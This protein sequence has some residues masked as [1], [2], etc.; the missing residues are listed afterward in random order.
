LL[1]RCPGLAGLVACD[2]DADRLATVA[3]TLA[4][5]GIEAELVHADAAYTDSLW[6]GRGFDRVLI[7]SPCS[8]LGVIRRHPDIKRLR[9]PADLAAA[10]SEQARLIERLWPLVA[11]GG[12]LV[13]VTCTVLAD[14]NERQ[15]ERFAAAPGAESCRVERTRQRLPGE[16]NMDGFYYA[17][18]LKQAEQQMLRV[19]PR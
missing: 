16:A 15:I 2:R 1:E 5:L 19:S 8:A 3:E 14:E 11:P 18:L 10:V 4:R 17:C 7:D 6:D 13:Y 9:R 12:R